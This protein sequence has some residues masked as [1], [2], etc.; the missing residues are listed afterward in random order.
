[1]ERQCPRER[2]S[3]YVCIHVRDRVI[4]MKTALHN[5]W[6]LRR[7]ERERERENER[8]EKRKIKT[9][10]E[11]ERIVKFA[12]RLHLH[13][14]RINMPCCDRKVSLLDPALPSDADSW[15][16]LSYQSHCYFSSLHFCIFAYV[17]SDWPTY[18]FQIIFS[19]QVFPI[20]S[21]L[22]YLLIKHVFFV[23]L[24]PLFL[25]FFFLIFFSQPFSLLFLF[26]SSISF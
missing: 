6:K 26:Y 20:I 19:S 9:E 25:V 8:E 17:L 14:I 23:A 12:K 18:W 2:D 13:M 10:R 24:L 21:Y 5:E 7:R 16:C 11:G 3:L 22:H 4:E 1:M 15:Q